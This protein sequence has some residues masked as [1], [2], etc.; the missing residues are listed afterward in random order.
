MLT[1]SNL[2]Y[3]TELIA[4][5]EIPNVEKKKII[6]ELN[7]KAFVLAFS[8]LK[9]SLCLIKSF[10]NVNIKYPLTKTISAN[11]IFFIFSSSTD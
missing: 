5:S 1:Q 11:K 7:G 9:L 2:G 4:K 8:S 10:T 6:N 3:E